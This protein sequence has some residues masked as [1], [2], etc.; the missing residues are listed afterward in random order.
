[1]TEGRHRKFCD[2]V[3]Q[4]SYSGPFAACEGRKALFVTERA[5]FRLDDGRLTLE[6]IAPGIDLDRDI[7]AHMDFK[8]D[9]INRPKLMDKRLFATQPMGLS[10]ADVFQRI[11]ACED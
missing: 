11:G 8:P 7:L 2:T 1:M 3:Q 6:E 9:L 4:V 5:V 10:E